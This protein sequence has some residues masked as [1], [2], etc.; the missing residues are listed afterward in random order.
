[1]VWRWPELLWL[2]ALLPL[3]IAAY[4]WIFRRRRRYAV[5]FSSLALVR[6]ALPPKAGLRR[7]A[8]FG[9]Y[10]LALGSLVGAAG[11]PS[12]AVRVPSARATVMLAVDVS[13]SMCSTDIPPTRLE[14]AEAAALSFI[15]QQGPA[16]EIGVVLFASYAMLVQPPTTD[17]RA[18]EAAV[19]DLETGLG[20]AIG[21]GLLTSLEAID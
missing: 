14:A 2:L 13:L 21:S 19:T 11:S 17:H 5:R 9:L 6:A 10:L 16:T 20:T 7:H 18:L 3:S 15:R 8:P 4:V 1:M 12:A